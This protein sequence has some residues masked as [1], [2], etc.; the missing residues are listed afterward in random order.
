MKTAY[1]EERKSDPNVSRSVGRVT[2]GD[3]FASDETSVSKYGFDTNASNSSLDVDDDS[4]NLDC[5]DPFAKVVKCF[6]VCEDSSGRAA[7]LHISSSDSSLAAPSGTGSSKA[8]TCKLHT[9]SNAR[10][11]SPCG[12]YKVRFLFFIFCLVRAKVSAQPRKRKRANNSKEWQI[13]PTAQAIMTAIEKEGKH[14][15]QHT[16]VKIYFPYAYHS[17]AVISV[18]KTPFSVFTSLKR[19]EALASVPPTQNPLTGL[20]H[21]PNM[22]K[23]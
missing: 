21:S 8:N 6:K 23:G 9:P 7:G 15:L 10:L 11:H 20:H 5:D 12:S 2:P 13:D 17:V 3:S 14:Y 22:C 19:G 16:D 18:R 4:V 1:D